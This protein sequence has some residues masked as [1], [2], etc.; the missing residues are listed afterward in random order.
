MTP[1]LARLRDLLP[2]WDAMIEEFNA[3]VGAGG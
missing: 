2:R 3:R 1:S